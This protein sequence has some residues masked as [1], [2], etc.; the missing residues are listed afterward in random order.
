M[1]PAVHPH[2]EIPKVLTP[3]PRVL[4]EQNIQVKEVHLNSWFLPLWSVFTHVA[5]VYANLL[6]PK[7]HLHEKRVQLPE[8]FRGAP[9]W[10]PFHCFGKPIW[11][12]WS[13]V[14]TLYFWIKV[15]T[16]KGR[17]VSSLHKLQLLKRKFLG[18]RLFHLD[19]LISSNYH[20]WKWSTALQMG[21]IH[22]LQFSF[23]IVNI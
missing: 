11:P 2:P 21:G 7:N 19:R 8:D 15:L 12:P 22:K 9:T 20:C 5:S 13:H 10:P 16:R 4:G 3:G 1:V 6:Q 18:S 14:K 17:N 23:F